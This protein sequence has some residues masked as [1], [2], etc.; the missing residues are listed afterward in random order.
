[1][2]LPTGGVVQLAIVDVTGKVVETVLDQRMGAGTFDV[3]LDASSLVSGT[4]YYQMTAG[5]VTLTRQMMVIK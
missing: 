5:G 1:L 3:T 4:Y 2:T